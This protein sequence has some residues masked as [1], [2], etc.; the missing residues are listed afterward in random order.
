LRL[1][2]AP[3]GRSV[4]ADVAGADTR[5][6]SAT[7]FYVEGKRVAADNRAPFAAS[8]PATLFQG[9]TAT[10]RVHVRTKD[11]RGV[12]MTRKAPLLR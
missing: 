4:R 9:V 11:G 8:L 5:W 1:R 2:L 10:V 6:V 7:S 12:T 3:A